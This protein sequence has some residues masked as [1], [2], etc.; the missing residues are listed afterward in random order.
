M[1][2]FELVT[3]EKPLLALGFLNDFYLLGIFLLSILIGWKIHQRQNPKIKNF[4]YAFKF[5]ITQKK[6]LIVLIF[7]ILVSFNKFYFFTDSK[8]YKF[9]F[10]PK[11]ETST[12]RYSDI[13][14]VLVFARY[15]LRRGGSKGSGLTCQLYT[16]ITILSKY[17]TLEQKSLNY[18]QIYILGPLLTSK[19]ITPHVN[20]VNSC[21]FIPEDKKEVIENG[22]NVN[23]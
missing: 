4:V 15:E 17:L 16:N 21:H 18:R 9:N 14:S 10:L 2:I 1:Y 13:E 8:I 23:L 5:K 19:N 12:L 11:I 7:S 6:L 22:F 20:Y 3:K